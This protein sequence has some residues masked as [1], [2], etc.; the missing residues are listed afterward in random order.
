M[1][2]R[3]LVTATAL[4]YLSGTTAAAQTPVRVI[5]IQQAIDEA[6]RNN[7]A[8]L[9][10]RQ[11][12]SI[13]EAG[14]LTA[15]LRPNPVLSG[16]A[17]SLDWL[18]TGFDEANGAGPPEYSVRVDLPLERGGKRELRTALATDTR[19]LTEVQ[20]A[21]SVRHLKLDVT[22]ACIDIVEAKA[23]LALAT[24]TMQTFEQLV[25][26]NE[27]RLT[28]GSIP[29]LE[30]TRSRVAMLQ[31]RGTLKTAQL[32]LTEARLK[33]SSLLGRQPTD[34]QVD[35][36]DRLSISPGTVAPD[37]NALQQIA[38]NTRPDLLA[39]H[40]DQARSLADLRLQLA[41]GKVDYTFGAEYRRQQGVNGR[42]NLLG[43][44]FSVPLPV[45][46]RNQGEIARASGRGKRRRAQLPHSKPTWPEK[47]RRPTRSTKPRGSC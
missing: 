38:R 7:L 22:L 26:L 32:A 4:S 16:G 39:A 10:E 28:S 25:R 36:S 23:K 12:M 17:N 30:V 45:F 13:A 3:M 18:G 19:Q 27:Q 41:Q 33:L 9:A 43:L 31:Y 40:S 14:L 21:E 46:N 15:Q 44:F 5:T 2:W 47:S 34:D 1:K 37:L 29:Q 11:N 20:L 6:V 42:G 8:L 35:I 24:D